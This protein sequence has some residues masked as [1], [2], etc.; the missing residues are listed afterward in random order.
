[1]DPRSLLVSD[2]S[3]FWHSDA[4]RG[5][6]TPSFDDLVGAAE[7]RERECDAKSLRGFKIDYQFDLGRLLTRA[8]AISDL[9]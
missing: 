2:Q 4:A 6:S 1:M 5:P 7:Q 9:P 3:A 8:S